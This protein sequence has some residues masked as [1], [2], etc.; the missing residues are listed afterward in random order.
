MVMNYLK[1]NNV[2]LKVALWQYRCR[3]RFNT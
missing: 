2:L 1:L 3:L